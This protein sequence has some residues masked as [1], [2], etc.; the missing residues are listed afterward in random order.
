MK[1]LAVIGMALL[2]VGGIATADVVDGN[3]VGERYA[4][5][6]TMEAGVGQVECLDRY[7][8]AVID[9]GSGL[10]INA[11]TVDVSGPGLHHEQ[12]DFGGQKPTPK[13]DA[14]FSGAVSPIDTA[15]L[16]NWSG[17]SG[18]EP[19]EPLVP[20]DSAEPTTGTFA[21]AS[22]VTGYG[23]PLTGTV[24]NLGAAADTPV[25]VLQVVNRCGDEFCYYIRVSNSAG[26]GEEF[27]G[28]IP[29]PATMGLLALGGL[30]L[31]RRR[32]S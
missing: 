25:D 24:V 20:N 21:P 8:F 10:P 22:E 7:T 23:S 6:I 12:Y 26:A 9:Q 13:P 2:L 32:R 11:L 5:E 30:G 27:S 17:L 28:C 31:I 1:K 15:I 4:L 18:Q 19:A 16:L 3:H 14:F 29:E